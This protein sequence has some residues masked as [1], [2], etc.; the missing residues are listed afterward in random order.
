LLPPDNA[1]GNFTKVVQRVAVRIALPPDALRSGDMRPGLSVVASVR[2]RD[3]S[4]PKPTLLGAL[5]FDA[6]AQGTQDKNVKP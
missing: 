6:S 4:L 2:T 3:E 1:T 5:G